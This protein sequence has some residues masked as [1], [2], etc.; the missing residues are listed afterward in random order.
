MLL[1]FLTRVVDES[2]CDPEHD[3]M[4]ILRDHVRR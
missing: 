3:V 2:D 4:F 1:G